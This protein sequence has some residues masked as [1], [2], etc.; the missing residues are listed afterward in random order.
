MTAEPGGGGH[1]GGVFAR[2]LV[3]DI[4]GIDESTN[5][6]IVLGNIISAQN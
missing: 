6:F 5:Q 1:Q 4:P 2:T 3:R